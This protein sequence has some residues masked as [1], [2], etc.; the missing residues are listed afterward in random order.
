MLDHAP[1][2]TDGLGNSKALLPDVT[3]PGATLSQCIK[4]EV[5]LF[6]GNL[7]AARQTSAHIY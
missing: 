2:M 1:I 6:E 3:K 5:D 4:G 7:T